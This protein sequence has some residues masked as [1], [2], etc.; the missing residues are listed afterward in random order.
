V[1]FKLFV[2]QLLLHHH[3]F[4]TRSCAFFFVFFL[5]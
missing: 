2:L 3:G 5:I 4:G 1:V